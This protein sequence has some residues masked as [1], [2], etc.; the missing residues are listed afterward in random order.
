[1]VTAEDPR[2]LWHEG[3]RLSHNV[4]LGSVPEF[5]NGY[6]TIHRLHLEINS[7]NTFIATSR[8]SFPTWNVQ[9]P[10]QQGPLTNAERP[11]SNRPGLPPY[12]IFVFL[13]WLFFYNTTLNLFRSYFKV[14]SICD[15]YIRYWKKWDVSIKPGKWKCTCPGPKGPRYPD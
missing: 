4:T 1:M 3:F 15:E 9:Y 13:V 11:R 7:G 8:W 14:S 6:T 10:W 12:V 2:F 5:R